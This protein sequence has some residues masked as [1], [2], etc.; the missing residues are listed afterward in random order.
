MARIFATPADLADWLGVAEAP[1][2]SERLLRNASREISRMT[3][4]STYD[5]DLA[6]M[7]TEADVITAFKEAT[8]AQAEW[9]LANGDN[10]GDGPGAYSEVKVLSITLKR[11]SRSDTPTGAQASGEAAYTI[12]QEAQL[13]PGEAWVW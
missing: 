5:T 4:A 9:A 10:A 6:G 12:L 13:L 3:V 11:A 2:G 1:A 8:C 7:P